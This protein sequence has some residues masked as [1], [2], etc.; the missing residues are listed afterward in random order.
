MN[1]K[2]MFMKLHLDSVED[3]SSPLSKI[4]SV[5][6]GS[7]NQISTNFHLFTK[8]FHDINNLYIKNYK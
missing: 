6:N 2:E 7:L 8:Q 1:T 5:K 3:Y 4:E